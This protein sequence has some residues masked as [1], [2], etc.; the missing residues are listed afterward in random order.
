MILKDSVAYQPTSFRKIII[1]Q[2]HKG[3]VIISET[4]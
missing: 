4:R 3:M 1:F 2:K